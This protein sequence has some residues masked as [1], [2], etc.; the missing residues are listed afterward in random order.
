MRPFRTAFL[1][2]FAL[3][4][5]A[6]A[7]EKP[8]G[9][10]IDAIFAP[11]AGGRIPTEMT[12]SPDG[13]RLSYF[14]DDGSGRALWALDAATGKSEVLLRPA[15]LKEAGKEEHGL[16]VDSY[17]WAPHGDALLL[18]AGGDLYLYSLAAKSLRRLT[19]T[20]AAE[21][22]PKFSPDGTRLAYVRDFD[23]HL[24]DLATGKETALTT[25]GQ[26]NAILNGTTDWVYWEE[27]WDRDATGYW[28]SPDGTRIAYYR[29]D[30]S[31]V[32]AFPLL[33]QS[34]NT[35]KVVLQKYPL[36]GE[37]VPAVKVGVLDLANGRTTWMET[38]DPDSFLARVD[39]APA[40]D[41]VAVQ[42]LSRDQK[43]LDLLRCGAA[44]G[45][46]ATLLTDS[47]PT[48]VNLGDGFRYLQD[49]RFLWGSERSGWRRLY[50]YDAGGKLVRP[51][52]PEGWSLAA[53][54]A[55]ADDGSWALFTGFRT[56][57]LGPIDRQVVRVRLADG[58]AESLTPAP[59]THRAVAAATGAWAHTWSDANTPTRAEV[60][61]ADG[62]AVAL[63]SLPPA[64]I[65]A[66]ALPQWEF[67]TL[68]GPDGSRLP[69]TLLKPA[70]FDPARRYPAIV[71]HYGGPGSQVVANQWDS[72]GR[73]LWSKMM[74]QRGFVVFS[75]DNQC[76]LFFGKQG[77]DRDYRAMGETALAGQLAGVDYLKSLGWVDTAHLG[78]WGWSGGGFNTL[79][80]ILHRPG[81]WKAAMAGAPVV[82][83]RLYDAI[84]TERYLGTPR[85]NPDG[86]SKSSPITAATALKDDL[87][88][89][90]GLADDNVHTLNSVLLT[91][92]LVTAG[93]PF[94]EAFYPG[95]KH[96]MGDTAQAHFLARMTEFFER[97][98]Q[99]VEVNDVKVEVKRGK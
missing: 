34:G 3:S 70:G 68:P 67:L 12:W 13:R 38:G 32:T 66:A 74:A 18:A 73:N 15:E 26:E 25:G 89:V 31:R 54:D 48:W 58:S 49:G 10:T 39:W 44:D 24:L 95:Q 2:L 6:A 96:G 52:S 87:L 93:L 84:W 50:L 37:P 21:T 36:P 1:A 27:I 45:R 28:W 91:A 82:D 98:L 90:H 46:C 51:V 64:G 9:L 97:T 81:V 80:S 20:A 61:R 72:H 85:E 42:R 59:G 86:Y 47:W 71:F 43:R 5:L 30:E 40:G 69:A 60:R 53:L 92:Q 35:P 16:T 41:A 62:T 99:G 83:W 29:F 19:T 76:S 78:L 75:V 17:L 63:P 23:L 11:G 79:Y 77:E 8:P 4:S 56:A 94:E 88:V 33:D 55:V 65:D 14:W 57:G 7:A 22:D